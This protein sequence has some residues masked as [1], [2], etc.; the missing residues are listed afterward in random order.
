MLTIKPKEFIEILHALLKSSDEVG[1]LLTM[2]VT[3]EDEICSETGSYCSGRLTIL[4][5]GKPLLQ[6]D[7]CG[8][9]QTLDKADLY[10]YLENGL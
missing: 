1:H 6:L 2:E 8:T 7:T 10:H 3:Q 4:L 5:E 9:D